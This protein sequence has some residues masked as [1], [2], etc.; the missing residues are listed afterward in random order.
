[1]YSCYL[2]RHVGILKISGKRFCID[3]IPLKT[4]R[5]FYTKDVILSET[6]IEETDDEAVQEY[7]TQQVSER[8]LRL[9]KRLISYFIICL[10]SP[11]WRIW[12]LIG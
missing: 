8:R 9:Y 4:V 6:G 2:C 1:M 7:L 3:K 12:T 11:N 5:P 10:A